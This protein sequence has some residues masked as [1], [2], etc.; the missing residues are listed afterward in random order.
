M[1]PSTNDAGAGGPMM[2]GF[3]S[4]LSNDMAAL[5]LV[6]DSIDPAVAQSAIEAIMACSG[7]VL[8]TGLGKSGA[9]A[10]RMAISL[11]SIGK[12]A[13]F[14]H[15][16]EWGH[17]DLGVCTK[18]DLVIGFSHSGKTVECIAAFG[19]IAKRDTQIMSITS[20]AESPMAR[21]SDTNIIYSIPAA[22]EPVGGAPTAS[23]V[24]QEAIVNAVMLELIYRT[25]FT[26]ADFR[27]NHPG[28]ALG[29]KGQS[30]I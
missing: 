13:H 12:P 1:A 18:D 29:G 7:R 26:A 19:H 28:G 23:V 16:A 25:G 6:K 15:A 17:G 9:V 27:F 5:T 24:A 22:L 14:V 10:R 2:M 3:E 20:G 11:A 21:L 8:T 30:T 4:S